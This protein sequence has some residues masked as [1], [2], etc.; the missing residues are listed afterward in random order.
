MWTQLITGALSL[1]IH[2]AKQA[3]VKEKNILPVIAFAGITIL[4]VIYLNKKK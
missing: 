2:P 3:P 1:F 4:T